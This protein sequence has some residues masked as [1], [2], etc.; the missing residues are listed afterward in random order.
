M[1][2]GGACPPLLPTQVGLREGLCTPRGR[3]QL[4]PSFCPP[5]EHPLPAQE[6]AEPVRPVCPGL[7]GRCGAGTRGTGSWKE[8]GERP[9]VQ[10]QAVPIT[11]MEP[12]QPLPLLLLLQLLGQAGADSL[13]VSRS[14]VEVLSGSPVTLRVSLTPPEPF[15][16]LVW[17]W[18]GTALVTGSLDPGAPPPLL[19]PTYQ[20]RLRFNRSD[21]TLQLGQARPSDSG[22]YAVEAI[23]VGRETLQAQVTVLVYEPLGNVSISPSAPEAEEGGAAVTLR[24]G[25][26]RGRVSWSR[27][28]G[29]A[30]AGDPGVRLAGAVLSINPPSRSHQGNYTCRISNPFGHGASTVPLTVYYGPD[31]PRITIS[32]ARDPDP[33]RY[34]TVGSNVSLQCVAPARPPAL[35]AWS[36]ADPGQRAV[37]WGPSLLLPRVTPAHAGPY[38]CLAT[39]PRT[40]RRLR[41]VANLTVAEPPPG[42]PRCTMEGG[43]GE[44][45]L[46]FLCSWPGGTPA[47]SLQF[48]GL[49]GVVRPPGLSPLEVTVPARPQLS[50]V[51]VTCLAH[52]LTASRNCTMTPEAPR[53]VLLKLSVEESAQGGVTVT[54]LASGCPPPA[55]TMWAR[56]GRPLAT[57]AGGRLEVREDGRRLLIRNF[58]LSHDLGNY[59]VL[60]NGALGA[61]GDR[62]TLTGPSI[63]SWRLQRVQEAVVLTWDVD[64]GAVL[65]GFQVQ[66]RMAGSAK[67]SGAANWRSLLVLGPG[68]RS[69]VVPLPSQTGGPWD[70]RILPTLGTQP[71]IPSGTKTYQAGPILGPG[72]IAGIVLGSLLAFGLLAT[73]LGLLICCLCRRKGKSDKEPLTL[74]PIPPVLSAPST[75]TKK[76]QSVTPVRAPQAPPPPPSPMDTTVLSAY[77]LDPRRAPIVLQSPTLTVRAATQV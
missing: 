60:C 35:L 61:G 8:V 37:P 44:R 34:V 68:E 72:A 12:C 39:N 63:L 53:A 49:P 3:D 16:L 17:R 29:R 4:S 25:P 31:P 18:N 42:V 43:P 47:P 28:G 48:V 66:A 40:Q 19:A 69:A 46:R 58:S 27:D 30:L 26:E 36:L 51:S 73:L 38:A 24:C 55:R 70:L 32:S 13:S 71:G 14:P 20:S 23:R 45:S 59:S 50:G 62:I 6:A 21:G 15:P 22:V 7:G 56:E 5:V 2:E 11:A 9:V 67:A 57:G 75:P 41:A 52:H 1:T 64:R 74:A 77:S 33:G 65:S 10:L 76:T 54:L